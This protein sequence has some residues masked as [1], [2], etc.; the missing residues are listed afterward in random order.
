MISNIFAGLAGLFFAFAFA[1][2]WFDRAYSLLG[3]YHVRPRHHYPPDLPGAGGLVAGPEPGRQD[4]QS[5][6]GQR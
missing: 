2:E 5:D 6:P 1:P 4:H 3:A